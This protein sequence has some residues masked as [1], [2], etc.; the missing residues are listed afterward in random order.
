MIQSHKYGQWKTMTAHWGIHSTT[1]VFIQLYSECCKMT[2]LRVLAARKCQH[3]LAS[4]TSSWLEEV[5]MF[6]CISPGI[7]HH[8]IWQRYMSNAQI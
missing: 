8:M 3:L 7:M 6:E 4:L 5:N 1:D 2:V